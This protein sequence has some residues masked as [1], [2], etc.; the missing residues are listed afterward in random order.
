MLTSK[1]KRSATILLILGL[2]VLV[3]RLEYT[4]C[5]NYGVC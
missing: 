4:D 1:L 5:L 3:S 2:Y